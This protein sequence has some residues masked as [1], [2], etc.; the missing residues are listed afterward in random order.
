ML[1]R[2]ESGEHLQRDQNSKPQNF[3]IKVTQVK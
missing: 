2:M 1:S 3:P